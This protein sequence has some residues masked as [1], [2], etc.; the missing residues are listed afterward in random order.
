MVPC[1]EALLSDHTTYYLNVTTVCLF[2]AVFVSADLVQGC[3]FTAC[4]SP[5]GCTI[6]LRGNT[7][8]QLKR[9]CFTRASE[10]A[11]ASLQHS[12]AYNLIPDSTHTE[13]K[14]KEKRTGPRSTRCERAAAANWFQSVLKKG[15]TP[16]KN[17]A[18]KRTSCIF[19]YA[20]QARA[21]NENNLRVGRAAFYT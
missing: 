14:E 21:D 11:H 1:C 6:S 12:T 4:F 2:A 8:C 16:A 5:Q 17:A 10:S 15:V 3:F 9:D 19:I 20:A 18:S 7:W 13:Q